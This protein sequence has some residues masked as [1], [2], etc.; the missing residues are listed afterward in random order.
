VTSEPRDSAPGGPPAAARSALRQAPLLG[1]AALV[2]WVFGGALFLGRL[3]YLRDLSSQYYPD[4]NFA[5]AAL[6]HGEWPLWNPAILA[7]TPWLLA[8]PP[9][10][11]L[12]LLS[13]A[14]GAL[15]FGPPLH[16]LLAMRGTDALARRLGASAAG[17]F[18]AGAIFGLSGAL[19]S[20][21]NLLPLL[22]GA[23]WLPWLLV[24]LLAL[25]E[26]ATPRRIGLLALCAAFLASTLA[27]EL[28]IH[29]SILAVAVVPLRPLLRQAR[30]L[31]AAALVAVL[32]AAPALF[33]A[34]S[35]LSGSARAAGF[36]AT[37]AFGWSASP[38]VLL[39][40]V[41]PRFFGDLHA[42]RQP[43]FWGAS[44]FPDGY[45]YL[46][47]LYLGPCVLALAALGRR[48]G[49]ALAALVCVLLAMG[50]RGP[51]GPLLAPLLHSLRTPVKFALPATLAL[52]LL[53]GFGLDRVTA[54]LG[55]G[56][57]AASA[58][59]AKG[60]PALVAGL[61]RGAPALAAGLVLLLAGALGGWRPEAVAGALGDLAPALASAEGLRAVGS[62][63]PAAFVA[64]GLLALATGLALARGGRLAALAAVAVVADLLLVNGGLNG[65]V[66]P[67][68]YTLRPQVEALLEPVRQG[69]PARIFSYGFAYS[70]ARLRPEALVP[71]TDAWLFALDRQSLLPRTHQ[72]DG[73]EGAFE[74]D[75]TGFS[76]SGSALRVSQASPASFPE[77]AA[78]LREANV[79]FVL[80][81]QP[82][83]EALATRL[84]SVALPEVVE[85]LTLYELPGALP[86]A[87]WTPDV[88]PPYRIMPGAAL[89]VSFE[90]AGP[91]ETAVLA[92]TPAGSIVVLEGWHPGWRAYEGG[93]EVALHP[94]AGRYRALATAGGRRRF[95]MRYEPA[96]R[97]PSLGLCLAGACAAGLLLAAGGRSKPRAADA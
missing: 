82:L 62:L 60:A 91:H 15:R 41:A 38:A 94:V 11:L 26:G 23:A 47:S 67:S 89:Q 90:R 20:L 97:L 32:L 30:A 49:L 40:A 85:P 17:A 6:R 33:G 81:F 1:H 50:D 13:G 45:P 42:L 57:P 74:V 52:A 21:V 43:S 87:F 27:V 36:D 29:A 76:P 79:R 2:A 64:S 16:V 66:A 69:Q 80:S 28:L 71:D 59:L 12:L 9:D 46:L 7:G 96:W 35:L 31:L 39:E 77:I 58:G 61:A 8:Y 86:R 3:P 92:D 19:L 63:W 25:S 95:V 72:L 88:A 65:F 75:R 37:E 18:T 44:Y 48:R 70:G 53:A 68:F 54:A 4:F 55:H 83:P 10:L 93:R 78:R 5:A 56:A 84:E 22:E 24:G 34:A 14:A 51:F 73:L